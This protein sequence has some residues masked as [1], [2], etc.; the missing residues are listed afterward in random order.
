MTR[1]FMHAAALTISSHQTFAA[2]VLGAVGNALTTR[3][4]AAAGIP[5]AYNANA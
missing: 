5:S 2:Q 3:R 1:H 4:A